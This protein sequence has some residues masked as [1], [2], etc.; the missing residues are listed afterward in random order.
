[1]LS[2]FFLIT[3]SPSI[4]EFYMR[5]V[6]DPPMVSVIDIHNSKGLDFSSMNFTY[7]I[8]PDTQIKCLLSF[9]MLVCGV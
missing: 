6:V 8:V 3:F 7:V 9:K 1:M 2:E 4:Y 5:T